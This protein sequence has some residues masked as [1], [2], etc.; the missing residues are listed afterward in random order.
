MNKYVNSKED[1]LLL[2]E[3][4][5]EL[6]SCSSSIRMGL[7][8]YIVHR[9]PSLADTGCSGLRYWWNLPVVGRKC[10]GCHR[11]PPDDLLTLW[12]LHNWDYIQKGEM[13]G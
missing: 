13:D 2:R 10:D 3:S 11:V 9:C 7:H 4:T 1:V 8:S 6:R 12:Q 5:W